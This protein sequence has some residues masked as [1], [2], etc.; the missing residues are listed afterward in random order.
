MPSSK[1]ELESA[2]NI[3]IHDNVFSD[4]YGIIARKVMRHHVISRDAKALYS[5]LC[6]F[7]GSGDVAFPATKTILF[8]LGFTPKTFYKYRDE[9]SAFGLVQ[10]ET[11]NTRHGRQTVYKL[12]PIP[13]PTDEVHEIVRKRQ[14]TKDNRAANLPNG[15]VDNFST[16]KNCGKPTESGYAQTAGQEPRDQDGSM[17][18]PSYQLGQYPSYQDGSMLNIVTSN[19]G[20]STINQSEPSSAPVVENPSEQPIDTRDKPA[21]SAGK[22]PDGLLDENQR[23]AFDALCAIS[24]KRLSSGRK[25]HAARLYADRLA[26]GYTPVQIHQAYEKYARSYKATNESPAYA[27]QLDN[28]LAQ[29]DGLAFYADRPRP[30]AKGRETSIQEARARLAASDA[31]YAELRGKAD[32]ARERMETARLS[33]L[34]NVADYEAEFERAVSRAN[35]YFEKH[36]TANR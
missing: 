12:P 7:A 17:A 33:G 6:S 26:Q 3:L 10:V 24:L 32:L 14:E 13:M 15:S 11:R 5:Y 31:R 36:A 18:K 28:W 1:Q 35:E 21:D 20:I 8:E 34:S 29:Q 2:E 19:K 4:G 22:L 27:K 30:A 9:L 23:K 25:P 16:E